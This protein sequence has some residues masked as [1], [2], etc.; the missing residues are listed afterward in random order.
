MKTEILHNYKPR[1]GYL[2]DAVLFLSINKIAVFSSK[3][4]EPSYLDILNDCYS[5]LSINLSTINQIDTSIYYKCYFNIG[6]SFG[7]IHRAEEVLMFDTNDPNNYEIYKIKNPFPADE[8]E[9]K[10]NVERISTFL[11]DSKLICGLADFA[12][13]GYPPRYISA[14]EFGNTTSFFGLGKSKTELIW[15]KLFELPKQ[16][17]PE[18]EFGKY[19]DDRDWLNI[20]ALVQIDDRILIHTTGGTSTRLKSGNA[21]EFNIIAVLNKTYTWENNFEIEKGIGNF[22]TDKEHFILH[23]GVQRNKLLFYD[24]KYFEIDYE[25]S[26]T[27][28]QNLGEEKENQI[29]VDKIGDTI[30]IYNHRFLNI[31]KLRK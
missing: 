6:K 3:Y 5:A 25:I 14:L 24:T 9:R 18:T 23:S 2:I 8:H 22:S 17:F 20:R 31:C 4:K 16:F 7:L 26:L 19:K 21:F 13:Y 11:V 28:K 1:E 15:H 30:L 12:C 27:A 10:T 29:K